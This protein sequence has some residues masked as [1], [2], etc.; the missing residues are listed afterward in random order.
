MKQRLQIGNSKQARVGVLGVVAAQ[1]I[2]VARLHQ[3]RHL[4]HG[5]VATNARKCARELAINT[6]A[7]SNGHAEWPARN[8]CPAPL[9]R[10]VAPGLGRPLLMAAR[11]FWTL[12]RCRLPFETPANASSRRLRILHSI[13]RGKAAASCPQEPLL[14]CVG[15][16]PKFQKRHVGQFVQSQRKPG[17][18]APVPSGHETLFAIG[19]QVVTFGAPQVKRTSMQ[20]NA[21]GTSSAH[22][23]AFQQ[24][25]K[26]CAD[27]RPPI[28]AGCWPRFSAIGWWTR[29][30]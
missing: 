17:S 25:W 3:E 4:P 19:L 8:E 21:T 16:R 6:A 20:H 12:I 2:Q 23:L 14:A 13:F 24:T 9:V 22:R 18:R 11:G 10:Q 27:L 26:F 1:E 28:P 30:T 29:V 15:G 7:V 5:S